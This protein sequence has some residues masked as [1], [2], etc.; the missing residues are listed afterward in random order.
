ML[1]LSDPALRTRLEDRRRSQSTA[2]ADDPAN[3]GL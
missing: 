3:E 1:A 2:I